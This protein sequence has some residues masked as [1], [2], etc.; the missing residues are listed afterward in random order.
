MVLASGTSSPRRNPR[1]HEAEAILDLNFGGLVAEAM[2]FLKNQ[3]LEHEKRIKRRAS[4]FL[5]ILRIVAGDRFE[6]G[7]KT[8]PVNQVAQFQ[9]PDDTLS[10]RFLMIQR[11]KEISTPVQIAILSHAESLLSL[12]DQGIPITREVTG[13]AQLKKIN[14]R[15]A[16]WAK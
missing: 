12:N 2:V 15:T 4:S 1:A 5:P 10:R 7:A 13:G 11:S 9:N 16:G 3:D 6:H 14:Y 8:L